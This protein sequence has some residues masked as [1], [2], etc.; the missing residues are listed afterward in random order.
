MTFLEKAEEIKKLFS[1]AA[2]PEEKYQLLIEL[3]KSQQ[4]LLEEE[5]SEENRVHGCQSLT[6]LKTEYR[7][8]KLY[9]SIESDALISAGLGQ[10]LTRVY[11]GESPETVLTVPP[12]YIDEI[13]I[14]STLSPGRAN[15]LASM[16]ERLR[17]E[18]LQHYI[19]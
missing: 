5:K 3:G 14:R 10:L 15:G 7:D 4:K 9:F 6:Y 17:K 18:A 16:W 19:G 8:G 11:N 1:K 12:K 13:G 2:V